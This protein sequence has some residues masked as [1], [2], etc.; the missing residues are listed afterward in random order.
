MR[1]YY[2]INSQ[3]H[4]PI[5]QVEFEQLV[6]DGTIDSETLLW[7]Q[8]M[9]EWKTLTEVLAANPS[10]AG[11]NPPPIKIS[12]ALGLNSAAQESPPAAPANVDTEAAPTEHGMEDAVYAGFWRRF[13]ARCIDGLIQGVAFQ[14]LWTIVGSIFFATSVA[15][16]QR[17]SQGTLQLEDLAEFFGMFAA[18]FVINQVL[19]LAYEL[20]FIS[21]F[22]A[23]PGKLAMGIK[24]FRAD[25]STLSTRRIVARHFAYMLNSFTLM[26]GCI[27]AA[28][29]PEARALHD[30][31]CDT[32]VVRI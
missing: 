7:K 22:A 25:G 15:K 28:F 19:E 4:G 14:I 20:Y 3:R 26:V 10:A 30:H 9:A 21:H 11:E 31:I 29:D 23:T 6:Q 2:A 17:L 5:E 1:W 24:I 8:G 32:R 18:M 16:L 27:I 12:V 13:L